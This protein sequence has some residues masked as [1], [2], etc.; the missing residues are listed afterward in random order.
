L[1]TQHWAIVLIAVAV[2]LLVWLQHGNNG[3]DQDT[4]N[5]QA[6]QSQSQ[7]PTDPKL[8]AV[9]RTITVAGKKLGLNFKPGGVGYADVSTGS[10]T[11]A[12][13]G[14]SVTMQYT[15]TLLDGT[16]FDATSDHGGAPFTCALGAHQVIPG[17]ELGIPGMKVGGERVLVIPGALAYGPRSP[18]PKIP[19]NAT[20][21]FDVKLVG[22]GGAADPRSRQ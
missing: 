21:V 2:G 7:A 18:S 9:P 16:K 22:V 6:S 3:T 15:G 5:Q 12:T 1:K 19:A 13:T 14:K 10:G 4:S 17:W 8:T 11:E 20:L